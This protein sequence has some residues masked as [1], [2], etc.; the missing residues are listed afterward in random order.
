MPPRTTPPHDEP[1]LSRRELLKALAALGGATAASSLLPVKW[2][3]PEIGA[4]AL[5]AHAQATCTEGSLEVIATTSTQINGQYADFDLRI[6]TPDGTLVSNNAPGPHQGVAH[7]GPNHPN[8]PGGPPVAV[9]SETACMPPGGAVAGT[10]RIQLDNDEAVAVDVIVT[11]IV[12]GCNVYTYTVSLGPDLT[13]DSDP[14]EVVDVASVTY[15]G[16]NVAVLRARPRP[17]RDGE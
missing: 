9:A 6:Y 5:P 1:A 16:G 17:A 10:Y 8:D 2:S 15:P 4:G 12:E 3:R 14:G 7:G 11:L 13:P